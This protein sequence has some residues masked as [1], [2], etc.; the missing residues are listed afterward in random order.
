MYRL[1]GAVAGSVSAVDG[2]REGAVRCTDKRDMLSLE[3]LCGAF[4][5]TLRKY[6]TGQAAFVF[7]VDQSFQH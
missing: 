7:S 6:F 1:R 5:V 3:L 2:L 4:A